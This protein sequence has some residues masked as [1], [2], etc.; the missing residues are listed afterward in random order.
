[1]K[2]NGLAWVLSSVLAMGV[3]LPVLAQPAVRPAPTGEMRGKWAALNLSDAQ[4]EQMRSLRTQ[5]REEMLAVLTPEQQATWQ[6][7]R[8]Q[9]GLGKGNRPAQ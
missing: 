8:A 9:R 3:V 4:K 1:M 2:R 7:L 6:T 5:G